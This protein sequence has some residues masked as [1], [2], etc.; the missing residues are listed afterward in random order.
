MK[1]IV[2]VAGHGSRLRPHTYSTNKALL[3]VAGRPILSHV[4]EPVIALEPEEVI[5]VIGFRGDEVQEYVTQTFSF[6]A[7]FVRQDKLLGLGYA[8]SLALGAGADGPTLVLLGDTIVELDLKKFIQAGDNVLGL[9]AVDDPQR[10]GIAEVSQGRI[11]GL[12]EK[13]A[14][15]K[16]NLAVVGLYYFNN[17]K[18]L[19]LALS[20]LL[21]SGQTTRGE[22]QL[23][24]ALQ[25]L[26]LSGERFT[27][28]EIESWFDCGKKDAVLA[29]NR[30]LLD[31][32]PPPT[33]VDGSRIIP[34]VYIASNASVSNCTLGPYASI[35]SGATIRNSTIRNSIVAPEAQIDNAT[36]EDS[37]V[38]PRAVVTGYTG[39]LNVG[40]SS[41]VI[42]TRSHSCE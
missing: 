28:F 35:S 11:L 26:I 6:K 5:F 8:V 22:V 39:Q 36:L 31:K 25:Q 37:L 20:Q 14:H 13:P 27:A 12:E 19:R 23:T 34:P 17:S 1:V 40:D 2:P 18:P 41:E 16:G 32:L 29:T 42:V 15:P 38:G 24:D 33:A 4:L 3:H 30:H 21:L 10:F 9:R 7:T